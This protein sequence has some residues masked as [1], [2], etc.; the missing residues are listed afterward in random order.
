MLTVIELG[1]VAS[2][3]FAPY[4]SGVFECMTRIY[5]DEGLSTLYKALGPRLA[6][7][8]PMIGIQFGVYEALKKE[9]LK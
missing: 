8:V 6:S 1:Q 2:D 9:L 3:G 5:R 7:V 4:N